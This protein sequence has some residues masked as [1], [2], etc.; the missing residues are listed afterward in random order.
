MLSFARVYHSNT[1]DANQTLGNFSSSFN[2]QLNPTFD[3]DKEPLVSAK[4]ATAQEACEH[5]WDALSS[6]VY[7]GKL[8]GA[9]AVYD[10]SKTVCDIYEAGEI[11]ASMLIKNASTHALASSDLKLLQNADGTQALF[12]KDKA[13]KWQSV[14]H[15]PLTLKESDAGYTLTLPNDTVEHYDIKGRLTKI[16]NAAQSLILGYDAKGRLSTLTNNFN[17][18]VTLS[19]DTNTSL[20]KALKSY[21]DTKLLYTYNDKHQLTTVTYADN[22]TQS[23]SYDAKGRLTAI[24]DASG[25]TVKTYTYNDADKVIE[26]ADTNGANAQSFSYDASGTTVSKNGVARAYDFLIQHSLAKVAT[27]T[28]DEGVSS[29]TYDA[30]GYPLSQTDKLGVTT[31]T[32]YNDRGLLVSRIDKAGT[33]S[34]E[35]TLKSYHEKFHKP[36]KVVKAGV[37]TF[38]S[39][40]DKGQLTKKTQGSVNPSYK[41]VSA[42]KMFG[43]SKKSLKSAGEIQTKESSYSYNDQGLPNGTTLPNGATNKTAYD[44]EGNPTEQTNALGFTAKT[45]KFDKAGR[46]LES[47]DINGRVTTTTYDT[48]GRVLT[49]TVDGQTTTY[50]YD[51]NGR[52]TKTTYP[53]GLETYS[54]YGYSR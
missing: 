52:V 21:D 37:A 13:G 38:Y 9:K 19:Y 27:V 41:I 35:I 2:K 26:T 11:K 53:D 6:K 42:K 5:G 7:L 20:L 33:D 43:Y 3:Y 4:Y 22:S 45:T 14:T 44:K 28:E 10:K 24:Q 49:A 17:Q 36:T 39:Y 50:E 46:P 51:S 15:A 32:T 54:K 34:E 18:S 25:T 48:M 12:Y 16:D 40:N 23:Y 47:I 31:L 1:K 8:S 29:Y 30:N